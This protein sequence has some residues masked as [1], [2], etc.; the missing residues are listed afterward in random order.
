MIVW[1]DHHLWILP[2]LIF[3]AIEA[4]LAAVFF[5]KSKG[6]LLAGVDSENRKEIY[7]SL[8]GSSS[9]LL[10]FS[11][12]AVAI[13]AAFGR[14]AGV[15]PESR[16]RE[17]R[18][19]NARVGISKVLLSTSVL[20]MTLLVAATVG[21]GIDGAKVGNFPLTSIVVSAAISSLVGLLVSGAGL[22]LSL[23]ERSREN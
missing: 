7:S 12:A 8:T 5:I 21:I 19:A 1:L 20:L 22:T 3:S 17:N 9:G 13:L 10:G 2:F 6:F 11:L 4:G 18:L 16:A 23:M 14:R 15:T